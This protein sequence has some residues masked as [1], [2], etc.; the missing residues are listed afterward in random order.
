MSDLSAIMPGQPSGLPRAAVADESQ[1]GLDREVEIEAHRLRVHEAA[2]RV[3]SAEQ[4]D[5]GQAF[6][7]GPTA[8]SRP[9]TTRAMSP[10]EG[11]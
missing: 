9:S 6:P 4:P 2:L 11:S 7:K 3:L 8:D 5:R 10:R 1:S